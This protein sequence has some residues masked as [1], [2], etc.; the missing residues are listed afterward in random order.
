MDNR[1]SF[2]ASKNINSILEEI[3]KVIDKGVLTENEIGVFVEFVLDAAKKNKYKEFSILDFND[4]VIQE[5]LRAFYKGY[6]YT[7]KKR[8][9]K[10][11]GGAGGG[12]G[13]TDPVTKMADYIH[14]SIG[15][16]EEQTKVLTQIQETLSKQAALTT[17]NVGSSKYIKRTHIVHIDSLSRNFRAYPSPAFYRISFQNSQI[18]N[19]RGTLKNF[20]ALK[21]LVSAELVAGRIPNF[22]QS[23]A[24]GSFEEPYLGL[25]IDEI[26]GDVY[27]STQDFRLF[28]ELQFNYQEAESTA[29]FLTINTENFKYSKVIPEGSANNRMDALTLRIVSPQGT[30][31]NFGN[32]AIAI[33]S[34]TAAS[35]TVITTSSVHGL[36]VG[37]RVYIVEH[38]GTSP[39]LATLNRVDGH[40]VT[41]VPSTTTF[42]VAV[43]LTS[44][45]GT[46][47]TGVV[48]IAKLQ[49]SM[50]FRFVTLV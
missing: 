1:Q 36:N 40:T 14:E 24:S 43:D 46:A 25:R 21:Q 22:Y 38:E 45:A 15:V 44:G 4:A 47:S 50:V 32:D 48:M 30:Q 6:T 49:N 13:G 29:T 19:T 28:A 12:A 31:F 33:T 11:G 39:A 2:I 37:D 26:E 8:V 27:S 20:Q 23:L 3:T 18:G 5:Y 16:A 17:S 42:T 41:S 34:S 35:P 10:G 7:P 9:E